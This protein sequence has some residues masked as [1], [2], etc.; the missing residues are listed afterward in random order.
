MLGMKAGTER[1]KEMKIF[2][3]KLLPLPILARRMRLHNETDIL[4]F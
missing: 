4:Q 3:F 1:N 2:C